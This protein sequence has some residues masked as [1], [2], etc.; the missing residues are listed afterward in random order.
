[1]LEVRGANGRELATCLALRR[2]VFIVG[3]G[4]PEAVEVDGLD[5]T[6]AHFLARLDDQPVGTARMRQV[7]GYAKAE[8]VAVCARARGHGV[9]RALMVALER[10]AAGEGLPVVVLNAQVPVR[11]FYER[12]GYQVDG[13]VFFEAGIAHQRMRKV[14]GG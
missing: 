1:M 13:Q 5:E 7:S 9:G 12:L 3:Q 4:V 14:L 2:E 6:C 11:A 8:R 10:H